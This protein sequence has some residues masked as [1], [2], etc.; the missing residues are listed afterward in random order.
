MENEWAL[1]AYTILKFN[2]PMAQGRSLKFSLQISALLTIHVQVDSKLFKINI[3]KVQGI[4]MICTAF[5]N[6][7]FL[8]KSLENS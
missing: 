7:M 8:M 6:V 2:E 4:S 5:D 1:V 3:V